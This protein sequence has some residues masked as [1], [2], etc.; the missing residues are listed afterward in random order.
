MQPW[1]FWAGGV[2]LGAAFTPEGPVVV[3][4]KHFSLCAF[5][6]C[7]RGDHKLLA[8]GPVS[9]VPRVPLPGDILPTWL[10]HRCP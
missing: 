8:E 10:T 9:G 1:G 3:P 5:G 6:L 2:L 4:L 7:L